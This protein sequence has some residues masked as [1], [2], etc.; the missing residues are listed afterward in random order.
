[1]SGL[2]LRAGARLAAAGGVLF[3]VAVW[4]QAQNP[5]GSSD[6]FEGQLKAKPNF[7]IRFRPPTAGGEVRLYTKKPVR[8]EKDVS[9]EGSDEVLIEYQDVRITADSARYDFPTKT[10]TLVGHVVIDQGPTRMSGDRGTFQI[11]AKTG[12]LENATADLAPT[13]H[14]IAKS[15]EKIGDA[16]YRVTDGIF[17]ACDVPKPDWSFRLSEAVITLDDYARMKNVT[18][19]ARSV[20]LLYTPYLIWPTKEDRASGLLVPGVGYSSSRGAYLGLTQYWVSGRSTDLTSSVDL[21]SKGTIG[22][23]EEFRWTPTPESAGVFQAYA[24]HDTDATVCVPLS[25]AP[26]TGGTACTLPDGTAGVYTV[27]TK[28]RWKVRLDHVSDDLPWGF[29]GVVA[30]RDY[31]DQEYLQDFERSF[32]L[33][34]ARQILSRAFLTKNFGDDSV[35][36]RFERSETF[37]GTTVTQE[38]LPSLEFSRRT[39]R[40]GESPL[41]FALESSASWL[42]INR[43]PNLPR[44]DYA[45]ADVHPTLSLPWKRIPWLSVTARVGGRFTEYTD[46]TDSAQTRFVGETL[47]RKYGEAGVSIVGPSFSRIFDA[48]IG[49]YGKFKHVIE[50]RIDYS[51]VS[52][53]STPERIPEYDEVDLALG[54]NQIRY[55]IVNRLL[56]R[57]SDPKKGAAAEI[58][59]LEIAQTRYFTLPQNLLENSSTFSQPI[60]SKTGP[61]EA[62]L[63]VAPGPSFH[64]DGRLSY[65][66][67]ASQV[68]GTSLSAAYTWKTS[69]LNATWFASRPVLTAPLPAGSPSPDSDQFRLA[70]GVD[71]SKAFR[72]DTQLNY[73][74]RQKL[75]LEDRSLLTFRASCFS[76]FLEVRQLRLPPTPRRDI[77]FVINLKDIG[78]L[79][80]MHQSVDRLFGQ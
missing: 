64:L 29:R 43:G 25:E 60:V 21:Y 66:S 70:A 38:R 76:V 15:I 71:I 61:V 49:P 16:T 2:P 23:G 78:T 65:D 74:A 53:V 80:D 10:A 68:T 51:W 24:V 77:R 55:A 8:Y 6:P 31:S 69:F 54:M 67:G 26:V 18:F 12:K 32:A 5:F 42:Y 40:I 62:T 45:R 14:V 13:Y 79:L 56:A 59:S 22:V 72:I 57:S 20:P 36:L 1:V 63:R 47:T 7:Q 28:D 19:R 52:Q 34:S 27:K 41:F 73:D 4:S 50:P 11:E 46:S 58:A 35:N 48:E 39:S 75:L 9:W 3:L 17:T 30:I 44:G 37:F 33:S